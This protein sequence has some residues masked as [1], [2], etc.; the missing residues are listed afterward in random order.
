MNSSLV[1][2]IYVNDILI[3]GQSEAE[4]NDLI[5][6]LKYDD[7]AL[8]KEGTVEGYLGIDIQRDGQ[9]ITLKQEGLT[10]QMIDTLGLDSKYSTSVDTPAKSAALGRDIYG[11]VASRSTHYASVVGMLLYLGHSCPDI[12]FATHQCAQY[13]HSPKQSHEDA[14]KQIGHYLKRNVDERTHTQPKQDSQH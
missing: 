9:H 5:E 13:N 1:V 6:R 14:L 3:Y 2:I 10:K 11:K 7:I 8:H 4:I 12:S